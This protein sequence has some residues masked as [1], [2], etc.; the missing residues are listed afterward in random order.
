MLQEAMPGIATA[1]GGQAV[2]LACPAEGAQGQH[3]LWLYYSLLQADRLH[4][5]NIVLFRLQ[6][7]I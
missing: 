4:G 3:V 1:A 5:A 6:L 2:E 7:R